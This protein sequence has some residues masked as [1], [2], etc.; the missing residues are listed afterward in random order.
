ML[1]LVQ[2]AYEGF[3]T[4]VQGT[5]AKDYFVKGLSREMQVALKSLSDFATKGLTELATEASRLEI[6]GIGNKVNVDVRVVDTSEGFSEAAVAGNA[7][8]VEDIV[9]KVVER[10]K[11]TDVCTRPESADVQYVQESGTQ[12]SGRRRSNR[13]GRGRASSRGF[14][15]S[16]QQ[17]QNTLKCRLCQTH[18]TPIPKLPGPLLSSVWE[19]WT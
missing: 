8:I 3:A 7:N 5:I 2:L 19:P 4:N 12:R 6:A 10:L 17:Q 1:E 13:G 14:P 15:P 11:S 9:S 16:S 18:R